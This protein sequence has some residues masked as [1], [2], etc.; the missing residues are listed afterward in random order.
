MATWPASLPPPA[1]NTLRE[2][3][4]RNMMR[5]SMDKGPAKTRRRTTANI[6]PLSFSLNLTEAQVQTLDD[7]FV[8]DLFSG[9]DEFDYTHPRTGAPVTARFV[10]E[11][12]YSEREGVLYNVGIA[13]EILP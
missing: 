4:P 10:Q 12:E 9:V 5:S 2:S 6:R 11:P 13:L 1:L 8:D 7:F 3:P